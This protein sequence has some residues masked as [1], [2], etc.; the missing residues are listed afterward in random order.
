MLTP[1]DTPEGHTGLDFGNLKSKQ[2]IGVT[3]CT[4]SVI[5]QKP[6]KLKKVT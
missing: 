5:V 2:Q 1:S 6:A 3:Y 4:P